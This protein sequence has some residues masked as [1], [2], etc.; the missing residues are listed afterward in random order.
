[1]KKI[2]ESDDKIVFEAEISDS[3]ANAI[4]RYV[5]HVPIL[6]VDEIEI[7]KNDSPLYDEVIAHRV[8]LIPLKGDKSKKEIKLKLNVNREGMVYSKDI[9]GDVKPVYDEIPLTYLGNEQEIDF[10]ATTK[11]GS[12]VEH[13]KFSPGFMF[14][15]EVAEITVDKELKDRIREVCKNNEIKEKGNKIT[16][17]DDQKK[18]ILDVC[19]GICVEAG[20]KAEINFNGNLVV[21][22]E[23][24]GQMKAEDIFKKSA[25]ELK[26]DLETVSKKIEKE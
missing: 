26:K 16:I 7:T 5:S 15:R 21:T 11:V 18:S 9:K 6:A 23:S 17:I 8:G 19:E 24:F 1:M 13:S 25:E 12:G 10:T 4:R 2:E 14:Y 3:L 20:K 22:V